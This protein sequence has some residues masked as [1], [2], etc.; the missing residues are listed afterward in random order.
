MTDGEAMMSETI[1]TFPGVPVLGALP[2]V[3]RD[4]LRTFVRAAKLG[5][6][7]HLPFPGRQGY[8]IVHP[9]LIK[10]VLVDN[11]KNY[12][13][14]TRGYRM[15]R[16][17][18]GEGLVTSEGEF[19][20]RQR[21]IAQ[22]A[23]HHQRI[24]AFAETMVTS[25]ERMLDQWAQHDSTKVIDI[26]AEMMRVTLEIV[27]LCLMSTDL[28]DESGVVGGAITE[29]LEGT[30]K[31]VQNPLTLPLEVPTPGNRRFVRALSRLDEVVYGIIR[32][33]Q[34]MQ[35]PPQDLLTM[36]ME[37]VD[38]ETGERMNEKHLRDEVLTM[39]SAGHET[40]ANALTWTF[41]LLSQHA[42]EAEK[43]RAELAAVLGG[44][45]PT[46]EDLPNLPYTDAVVKESMRLLPPVWMIARSVIDDDVIGGHTIPAGSMVFLNTYVTH[47]DP[48][49][50]EAPERFMPERFARGDVDRQPKYAYFPFAGGPR[51]CIGNSFAAMEAKLLL[52]TIAQRYAPRLAPGHDVTPIP[53][54]TL[55]PKYGMRMFLERVDRSKAAA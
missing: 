12:G 32:E 8:L 1:P 31:R 15:L 27:G 29:V 45:S 49:F 41:Y 33:R 4:M 46:L 6:V 11:H 50:F 18:L 55:R 17:A 51:V 22:P 26:D 48:R 30:V 53:T 7:V 28:A 25:T 23:F 24:A 10:H 39:V 5:D 16:L 44:R 19:W 36:F 21:R 54:V 13:K 40:T 34:G 47:R 52:A 38:E 35:S 14:G 37:A 42:E 9:D 2:A 43:L 3:R 20:R